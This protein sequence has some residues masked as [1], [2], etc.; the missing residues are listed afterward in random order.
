MAMKYNW[1]YQSSKDLNNWPFL[2][3]VSNYELYIWLPQFPLSIHGSVL[4]HI[5]A[6]KFKECIVI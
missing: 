1:N 4:V 3:M 6:Y 5:L 2:S